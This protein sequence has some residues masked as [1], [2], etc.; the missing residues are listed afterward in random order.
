MGGRPARPRR[1]L[2]GG[3][4]TVAIPLLACRL[5]QCC[6]RRQGW[7][8]GHGPRRCRSQQCGV[9]SW[10]SRRR[11]G[12]PRCCATARP[13]SSLLL[14]LAARRGQACSLGRRFLLVARSSCSCLALCPR[15]LRD[16]LNLSG[17]VLS[18]QF[19][20]GGGRGAVQRMRRKGRGDRR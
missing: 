17:P 14:L 2:H 11:A 8:R 13:C 18:T 1:G 5:R 20:A 12:W 9:L 6:R 16:W 10:E 7:R 3:R 19:F 4:R 15:L